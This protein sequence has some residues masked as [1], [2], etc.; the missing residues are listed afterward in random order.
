MIDFLDSCDELSPCIPSETKNSQALISDIYV[1]QTII[2]SLIVVPQF[3]K[4]Y[5][6]LWL[7]SVLKNKNAF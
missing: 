7:N 6:I 2:V 3:K 1:A 5:L 4:P